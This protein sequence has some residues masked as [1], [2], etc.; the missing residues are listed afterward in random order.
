MEV[1]DG[2]SDPQAPLLGFSVELDTRE[3][4]NGQYEL[5][6]ETVSGTGQRELAAIRRIRIEN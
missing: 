1:A 3:F 2:G 5:A 6:V 4:A